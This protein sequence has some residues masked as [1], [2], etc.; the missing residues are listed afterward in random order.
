MH[1][2]KKN[3]QSYQYQSYVKIKTDQ[4]NNVV[5]NL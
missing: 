1:A 4:I 2:G 3:P 5:L